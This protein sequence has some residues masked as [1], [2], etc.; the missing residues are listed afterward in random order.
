MLNKHCILVIVGTQKSTHVFTRPYVT[1]ICHRYSKKY[2]RCW[3]VPCI[4]GNV[5]TQ[6]DTQGIGAY[7]VFADD[8][9]TQKDTFMVS[10]VVDVGSHRYS[11]RCQCPIC[12][13]SDHRLLQVFKKIPVW[14]PHSP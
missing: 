1:A 12:K 11:K 4:T 10:S 14:V 6:K 3:N 5:G 7:S 9:G 2:L 8:A 13:L